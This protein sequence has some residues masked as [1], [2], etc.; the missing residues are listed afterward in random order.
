MRMRQTSRHAKKKSVEVKKNLLL[1]LIAFLGVEDVF[2]Q[3]V[4]EQGEARM[5][6]SMMIRG[7]VGAGWRWRDVNGNEEVY[8]SHLNLGRG[9]RLFDLFIEGTAT[10]ATNQFIDGFR[11]TSTS[12]FDEP[13]QRVSGMIRKRGSYQLSVDYREQ[14]Y[15]FH[16][17]SFSDPD[18]P[19]PLAAQ[20][21]NDNKRRVFDANL[22]LTPGK[23]RI[24]LG[25]ARST[26]DG[27][28]FSTWDFSRDEFMIFTP[29][30]RRTQDFRASCDFSV[31]GVDVTLEQIYRDY[32]GGSSFDL[33]GALTI[34]PAD[35][36]GNNRA[37]TN[38]TKLRA[39][40]RH[41]DEDGS[42]PVS[43]VAFH[44]VV[45]ERI[46]LT[47]RYVFSR[48]RVDFAGSQFTSG[49]TFQNVA[50]LDTTQWLGESRRPSHLAELGATY[51]ISP[52][53]RM[54][55]QFRF[56]TYSI[57]GRTEAT[58][59]QFLGN[60]RTVSDEEANTDIDL[61]NIENRIDVEYLFGKEVTARVGYRFSSR[62]VEFGS[63]EA[64]SVRFDASFTT[65]T[66]LGSIGYRVRQS[67]NAFL[68]YQNGKSDNA[69]TRIEP[70]KLQVLR[71][72]S[73]YRPSDH[74]TIS[75]AL[76]LRKTETPNPDTTTSQVK[77]GTLSWSVAYTPW[78]DAFLNV[79]Y[80]RMNLESETDI[81]FFSANILTRGMSTYGFFNDNFFL[82]CGLTLFNRVR[83]EVSYTFSEATR[84]STFPTKF[85]YFRPRVSVKLSHLLWLSG[86][87]ILYKYDERQSNLQDY[88]M[89]GFTASLILRF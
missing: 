25:Y 7:N 54:S 67:L 12:L 55:E 3:G 81:R 79:G 62:S 4:H 49:V 37:P 88:E 64:P 39:Y 2:G 32:K 17:P 27:T 63:P 44:T 9:F 61:R 22:T 33:A 65:Q 77:H 38:R 26:F 41:V 72:R 15:F 76:I 16:F 56:H 87:F 31:R 80:N 52:H 11:I 23:L 24:N 71:M 34:D 20:H 58:I 42:T 59:R 68:E 43:R 1:L 47:G 35:T 82:D 48:G 8:K 74:V 36:L 75:A 10:A 69:F 45:A 83:A 57:T 84:V 29:V 28:G 70:L 50:L 66:F 21:R 60:T 13:A 78:K 30:D 89:N 86:G 5:W 73:S 46:D 85:V 19:G 40:Q 51:D 6:N 53:L 14:T 18:G